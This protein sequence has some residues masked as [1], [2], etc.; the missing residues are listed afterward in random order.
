[1]YRLRCFIIL[2]PFTLDSNGQHDS[3]EEEDAYSTRKYMYFDVNSIYALFP[4]TL[5]SN[6]QHDSEE[7]EDAYSTRKYMYFDVNSIYALFPFTLDSNGQHDSEEE[8]DAYSTRK[9][10]YFHVHSIYTLFPRMY[11]Y[12]DVNSIYTLFPFIVGERE[13]MIYQ[14]FLRKVFQGNMCMR[15]SVMNNVIVDKQLKRLLSFA[16]KGKLIFNSNFNHK[17]KIHARV[18]EN[19]LTDVFDHC[20]SP[21]IEDVPLVSP[22]MKSPSLVKPESATGTEEEDEDE[23]YCQAKQCNIEKYKGKVARWIQCDSC[24]KWLHFFCAGLDQRRKTPQNF[25]CCQCDI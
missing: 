12:F 14:D 8:E 9:Y 3:E 6:G 11:M 1:M 25:I 4:F 16:I 7:E 21:L 19:D 10:M 23:E 20:I 2:F 24:N 17:Q 15:H 22:L 5:D 18:L 13:K